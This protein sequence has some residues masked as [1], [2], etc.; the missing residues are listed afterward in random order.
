MCLST[1]ATTKG[2][3]R[4]KVGGRAFDVDEKQEDGCD[5]TTARRI[6]SRTSDID[7]RE[8]GAG[9]VRSVHVDARN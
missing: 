1:S 2:T 8:A 4:R 6:C 7:R 5:A 9:Q 3:W